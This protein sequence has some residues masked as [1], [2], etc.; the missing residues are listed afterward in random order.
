MS[1]QVLQDSC[2]IIHQVLQEPSVLAA[3][4]ATF[5]SS[6]EYLHLYERAQQLIVEA[7][8]SCTPANAPRPSHLNPT[9][10]ELQ[11]A[12]KARRMATPGLHLGLSRSVGRSG[13]LRMS[14]RRDKGARLIAASGGGHAVEALSRVSA[15]GAAGE[16]LRVRECREGWRPD[17]LEGLTLLVLSGIT[18]LYPEHASH[19]EGETRREGEGEAGQREQQA[20]VEVRG[21]LRSECVS[22]NEQAP[23]PMPVPLALNS[24]SYLLLSP[25]PPSHP[26]STNPTNLLHL[27]QPPSTDLLHPNFLHLILLPSYPPSRPASTMCWMVEVYNP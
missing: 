3:A 27:N 8:R 13:S 21:R 26:A 25:P 18:R 15:T 10:A 2:V 22:A 11:A 23:V 19:D 7:E 1:H 17:P 20:C 24:Q 9:Q 14:L 16:G 4:G 12:R 5:A 6:R